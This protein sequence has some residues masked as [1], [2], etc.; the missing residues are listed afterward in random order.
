MKFTRI[1]TE[2]RFISYHFWDIVYEWENEISSS[3]NIP[4]LS[5]PKNNI[6]YKSSNI[7][8]RK[9]KV[10]DNKLFYG[11]L[12]E[13]LYEILNYTTEF[14]LY[15]AMTPTYIKSYTNSRKTI[16][17]IIDFWDKSKIELFKK[18]YSKSP[19][20][21]ITSL[22]VL[23]YLKENNIKNKLIHF[24][25]SLP[26]IYKLK[27]NQVFEKRYDIV[28]AGRR[29][30]VLW[31]YLK[32]YGKQ[33]PQI[34][35]LRAF[36]RKGVFYYNSNKRGI[37]EIV[38]N[39]EEYMKLIRSARIVF[40]TTPGIDDGESRTNGFN[41]VTPR[42]FELLS[43]GCQVIARYPKNIDTDFFQLETLCPSINS[44]DDFQ[45]QLNIA[46]NSAQP[47][48]KNSEYLLNHYTSNRIKIL[49]E[50]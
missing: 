7:I 14:S 45:N 12:N 26:S 36:Q 5:T 32:E 33:N 34:E 20:I 18:I 10:I 25:V 42:L 15:F 41:P 16:P 49:N 50:I 22:E 19:Y 28:W 4:L 11:K 3:L 30:S 2:R 8:Y 1:L 13:F 6:L 27:L 38:N 48:K 35:Y 40:Y 46:L 47:I 24:P 44:Y 17:V 37:V 21:L 43:A 9:T 23:N 39:R 29:N 31:N